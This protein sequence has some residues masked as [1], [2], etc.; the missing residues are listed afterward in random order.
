MQINDY[1]DYIISNKY[2]GGVT[3]LRAYLKGEAFSPQHS[4]HLHFFFSLDM[5]THVMQV[6]CL[7]NSTIGTIHNYPALDRNKK[8]EALSRIM[9]DLSYCFAE[10]IY[11]A[12]EMDTYTCLFNH[13]DQRVWDEFNRIKEESFIGSLRELKEGNLG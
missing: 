8:I 12:L 11:N 6:I 9:I 10:Q 1:N 2:G 4:Y 5:E 3:F 13:F 7:D